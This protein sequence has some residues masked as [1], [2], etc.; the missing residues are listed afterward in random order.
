MFFLLA[1]TLAYSQKRVLSRDITVTSSE[2]LRLLNTFK[3][4]QVVEIDLAKFSEDVTP[5][6]ETRILWDIGKSNNLDIQ[7]YPHDIRSPSFKAAMVM[8]K[9]I[10]NV[11][12]NKTV[13]YKGYLTNTGNKVRLT[14]TDNF[15]YGSI[16]TDEGLLMIDQLKYVLKDKSIPSNKLVIYNNNNV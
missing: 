7:L 8:E 3:E 5:L 4:Y 14:I 11:E 13:T 16:Q 9:G 2:E 1:C 10:T 15:I 12:I 6:K